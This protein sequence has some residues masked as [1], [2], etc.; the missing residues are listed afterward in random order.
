RSARSVKTTQLAAADSIARA[1]VQAAYG[2]LPLSFEANQGQ[3]DKSVKFLSH[4]YGQSLCLTPTEAVIKLS[5]P[6]AEH[7]SAQTGVQSSANSAVRMKLVRANREP[8]INALE[9]LPGKRH[10]F[11]GND[12]AQWRTDVMTYAKVKYEGVYPGVDVVYYG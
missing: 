8:R 5:R 7:S 1:H 2:E 9:P 4:S 10:Y 11:L 12:P 6:A 3:A